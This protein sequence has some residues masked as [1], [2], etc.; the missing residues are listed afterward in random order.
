MQEKKF[1]KR[2]FRWKMYSSTHS[3]TTGGSMVMWLVC[4]HNYQIH[5]EE[6]PPQ[7]GRVYIIYNVIIALYPSNLSLY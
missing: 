4:V 1:K 5:E 7:N 3:G 2:K 6:S